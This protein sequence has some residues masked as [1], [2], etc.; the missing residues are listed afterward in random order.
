MV[1]SISCC[2]FADWSSSPIWPI[3]CW[4]AHNTLHN[5]IQSPNLKD[6]FHLSILAR[7]TLF[8]RENGIHLPLYARKS[9]LSVA[10]MCR[11]FRVSRSLE[12]IKAGRSLYRYGGKEIEI[13]ER[14]QSS[15]AAQTTDQ[16]LRNYA[17]RWQSEDLVWYKWQTAEHGWRLAVTSINLLPRTVLSRTEIQSLN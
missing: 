7:T 2:I 1:I 10:E 14:G 15:A 4:R 3:L 12:Y 13:S 6:G 8:V 17:R 9:N 16:Y 11:L 5:P